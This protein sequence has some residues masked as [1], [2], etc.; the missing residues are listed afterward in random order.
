MAIFW[1][2]SPFLGVAIWTLLCSCLTFD[3]LNDSI[4]RAARTAYAWQATCMGPRLHSP[5]DRLTGWASWVSKNGRFHF[6]A[7]WEAMRGDKTFN[8]VRLPLIV[9]GLA[10]AL[11]QGRWTIWGIMFLGACGLCVL[12]ASGE[13]RR[14]SG[15][16]ELLREARRLQAIL[17]APAPVTLH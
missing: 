9:A 15:D 6:D 2:L 13:A 11:Q 14:A 3:S 4:C 7:V 5:A 12:K 10:E 8:A 16:M 1:L 17:K